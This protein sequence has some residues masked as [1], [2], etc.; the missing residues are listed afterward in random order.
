MFFCTIIFCES[1]IKH[2]PVCAN[3][4]LL[5]KINGNKQ[6]NG[7]FWILWHFIFGSIYFSKDL[8]F[9]PEEFHPR[10]DFTEAANSNAAGARDSV[11]ASLITLLKAT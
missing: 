6:F 10:N 9:P 7:I 2:L 1:K 3:K 5:L 8:T 11:E 4:L